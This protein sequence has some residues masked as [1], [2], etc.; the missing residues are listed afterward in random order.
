MPISS[1]MLPALVVGMCFTCSDISA[2]ITMR[3]DAAFNA[4]HAAMP[5]ASVNPHFANDG[6]RDA[7]GQRAE[8]AR[9]VELN[10]VERDRVRQIFL[11]DERR[12]ERLIGRTAE[13]LGE[14]GRERQQQDVPDLDDA[15]EDE[16][17]Q[18]GR[19]RH[20]DVLRRRAASA[21]DR[22]DRPAR[23]R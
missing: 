8:H 19:R 23:R 14:A 6:D 4:K 18:R 16:Q 1:R 9:D 22:A 11:V 10:R 21:G 7:E 17:G 15:G 2:Q 5:W 3:N 20:L 13:R 12:D